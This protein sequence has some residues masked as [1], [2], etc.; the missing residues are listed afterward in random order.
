MIY[1]ILVQFCHF[2]N[3][4]TKHTH[5]YKTKLV[6]T[7]HYS[8][9]QINLLGLLFFY[10][11]CLKA[12]KYRQI[13]SRFHH[14]MSKIHHLIEKS[15]VIILSD[16]GDFNCPVMYSLKRTPKSDRTRAV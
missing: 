13:R 16:S 5:I 3:T 7:E 11:S 1:F 9:Y 2:C 14:M 12:I 8:V 4:Q 15:F 10:S 6:K